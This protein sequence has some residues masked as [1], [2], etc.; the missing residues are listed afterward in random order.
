[1]LYF[2]SGTNCGFL[3]P[4]CAMEEFLTICNE[5]N[6]KFE[7]SEKMIESKPGKNGTRF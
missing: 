7:I 5:K 4:L 3:C 1:M 6:S 2:F